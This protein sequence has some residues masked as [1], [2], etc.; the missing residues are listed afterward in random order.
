MNAELEPLAVEPDAPRRRRWP[1][2]L[3]I[4]LAVAAL[5]CC[6]S[7][8]VLARVGRPY[9]ARP[10]IASPASGLGDADPDRM[11]RRA[12]LAE[13]EIDKVHPKGV[14]I[15]VDTY[16]NR[17]HLIDKGKEIRTAICST[18]TGIV[19]RDPRNGRRWVFDTPMGERVV[20][21]K[22]QHPVW[23]KPDWAFIEDG[24]LPP[25]DASERFDNQSLGDYALYIGDGYIIHGTL[26]KSLLGRRVTHGCIRLGDEDLEFVYRHAPIGTR[27]YLY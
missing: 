19:L 13:K 12:A 14:Y 25:K 8:A 21:R 10:Y 17:L 6:G 27:V 7:A 23:A 1:V 16:R 24:Y 2:V 22:V 3:G 11:V 15:V 4:L 5:L 26:F 9:V 20:E 18:G